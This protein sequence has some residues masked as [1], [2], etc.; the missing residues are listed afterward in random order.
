MLN[1][2]GV[3]ASQFLL[4]LP[5]LGLP[6]AVFTVVNVFSSTNI[7]LAVLAAI[8]FAGLVATKLWMKMLAA[9]LN[10]KRYEIASDFR[11]G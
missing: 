1:W 5:S 4:I 3:G 11:N 6:I 9:W 8:G 7:A 2:Q 10:S